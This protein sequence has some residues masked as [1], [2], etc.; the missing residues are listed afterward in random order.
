MATPPTTKTIAYTENAVPPLPV[1]SQ[2]TIANG[3]VYRSLQ[4]EHRLRSSI[5]SG[6]RRGSPPNYSC[7]R[8]SFSSFDC[9]WFG[10]RTHPQGQCVSR[11]YAA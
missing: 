4:W 7:T 8:E 9:G 1:F 5:E 2:A 10:A 3:L 11:E 6:P